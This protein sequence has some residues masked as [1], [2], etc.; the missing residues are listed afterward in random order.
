[1][2]EY[3]RSLLK[4]LAKFGEVHT[5]AVGNEEINKFMMQEI[6]EHEHMIIFFN[7]LSQFSS[8]MKV[9]QMKEYI[10]IYGRAAQVFEESLIP[11]LGKILS[12]LLKK[13]QG[14]NSELHGVISDTLGTVCFHIVQKGESFE[15]QLDLFNQILKV[16]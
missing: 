16:P 12:I 10:K 4:I 1:M 9:Q 13:A 14:G 11:Y 7:K 2:I 6:R 8:H 5:M 15:Q 3:E